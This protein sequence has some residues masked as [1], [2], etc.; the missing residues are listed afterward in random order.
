MGAVEEPAFVITLCYNT[1]H[2]KQVMNEGRVTFQPPLHK[3]STRTVYIFMF[4]GAHTFLY[5]IPCV[6]KE[7]QAPSCALF[8]PIRSLK[9]LEI[10]YV[11]KILHLDLKRENVAV[12]G[13]HQFALK[14]C[15][16]DISTAFFPNVQACLLPELV[17]S[18][19]FT[20]V[21]IGGGIFARPGPTILSA[22]TSG[23]V[24]DLRSLNGIIG[25]K[26]IDY[27]LLSSCVIY[28]DYAVIQVMSHGR[29]VAILH[30]LIFKTWVMV[31]SSAIGLSMH[32]L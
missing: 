2:Y 11:I 20:P 19:N 15:D 5:S 6:K 4:F 30:A 32:A 22:F 26:S 23:F 14:T 1:A 13:F 28:N 25:R 8:H 21:H 24:L 9:R 27:T 3:I 18:L 17:Q 7:M 12:S 10:F 31:I 29:E 16:E